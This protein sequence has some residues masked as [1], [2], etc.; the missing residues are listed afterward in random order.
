M[1]RWTSD[2]ARKGGIL[3]FIGFLALILCRSAQAGIA[4]G[5]L[6]LTSVYPRIFSPNGD[7]WNDKAT[8]HFDNP[9]L[10]PVSGTVY[11]LSGARVADLSPGNDPMSVLSWDGKD[12]SGQRV[13]GGIYL[14]EIDFQ[15]KHATGTVVVAR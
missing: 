9:E 4:I 5:S 6:T 12:S 14:Y 10:L 7:G 11:D 8:F 13:A 1:I 15:G 3:F 2:L